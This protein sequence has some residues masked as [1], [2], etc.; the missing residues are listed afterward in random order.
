MRT[1]IASGK[2]CA[3]LATHDSSAAKDATFILSA[4]LPTVSNGLASSPPIPAK[5]LGRCDGVKISQ[6]ICCKTA[7]KPWAS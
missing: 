4:L 3:N 2:N 1:G 5:A 6:K 7:A